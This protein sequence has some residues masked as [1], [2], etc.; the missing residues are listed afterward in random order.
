MAKRSTGTQ[1]ITEPRTEGERW[2]VQT[3]AQLAEQEGIGMPEVGVF[4]S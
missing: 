1:L 4:P 2:L 3:V